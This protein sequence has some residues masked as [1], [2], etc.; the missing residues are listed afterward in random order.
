MNSEEIAR[1]LGNR[2]EL[3]AQPD[4]MRIHRAGGGEILIAPNLVQKAIAAERLPG[5]RNKMPEQLKLLAGKVHALSAAQN[6]VTP[7]IHFHVA[8]AITVLIFWK[9]L[10]PPKNGLHASEEFT[11]G[12]R[13]GDIIVG[14]QLEAD[15]L[16]HL[17]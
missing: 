13:L 5:M 15:N 2:F 14:S 8:E 3:L 11:D 16:I 12:K 4:N 1:F 6:L 7:Q 17:L 10:R 9:G